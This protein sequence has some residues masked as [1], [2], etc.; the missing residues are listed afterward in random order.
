MA[1][2]KNLPITPPL[3]DASHES[4]LISLAL[5]QAE[6]QLI[7][8]TASSQ[9][10]TH[11]LELGSLRAQVVLEKL[12]LENQLLEARIESEQSGQ[13]LAETIGQ[14]LDALKSYSYIPPGDL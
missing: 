2:Q 11:F 10:V 14:V 3:N 9:I 6:K 13:K 4:K 8:Q 1:K 5:K 12:K 7:D